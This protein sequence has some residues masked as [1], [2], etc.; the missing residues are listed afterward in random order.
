[1]AVEEEVRRVRVRARM[2]GEN[3]RVTLGVARAG[4]EADLG[5]VGSEPLGGLAAFGGV[6]RVGRHRL[7][8]HEPE[9]AFERPV[10]ISV[11]PREDGLGL[12]G[13]SHAGAPGIWRRGDV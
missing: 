6:G 3:N 12:G 10:E 8:A 7:E 2:L 11:D 1:M 5:E 9:E 4:G 13:R